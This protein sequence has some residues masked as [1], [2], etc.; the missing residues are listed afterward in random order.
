MHGRRCTWVPWVPWVPHGCHMGATCTLLHMLIMGAI[1]GCSSENPAGA[2]PFASTQTVMGVGSPG[3]CPPGSTRHPYLKTSGPKLQLL[4]SRCAS[5]RPGRNPGPEPPSDPD[6]RDYRI[7]LFGIADSL[8]TACALDLLSE[9]VTLRCRTGSMSPTSFPHSGPLPRRPLPSTG[10]RR[11]RFPGFI[12]HQESLRLPTVHPGRL[13]S[14][15][16][17]T[18]PCFLFRSRHR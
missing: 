12:G 14:S 3:G 11:G 8:H 18:I 10:S 16:S 13:V 1:D 6:V 17:G 5:G 7:R 9:R 15:P 2:T 4:R